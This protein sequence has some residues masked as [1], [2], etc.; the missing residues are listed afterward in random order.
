MKNKPKESFPLM[1]NAEILY[2]S[3]NTILELVQKDLF[4]VD[5]H[6]LKS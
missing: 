4:S 2:A 1:L 6:N 5:R 3:Q